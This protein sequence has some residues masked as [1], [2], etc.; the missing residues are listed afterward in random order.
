MGCNARC[1]LVLDPTTSLWVYPTGCLDDCGGCND[2]IASKVVDSSCAI[3]V[4][5]VQLF[6][7]WDM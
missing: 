7:C 5:K 6:A 3:I 4:K 2:G 1:V